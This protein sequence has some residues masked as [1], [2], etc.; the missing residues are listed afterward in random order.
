MQDD[1][2]GHALDHLLFPSQTIGVTVSNAAQTPHVLPDPLI[3]LPGLATQ[4]TGKETVPIGQ[5]HRPSTSTAGPGLN[6]FSSE[7][8]SSLRPNLA[9]D[10]PSLLDGGSS[11]ASQSLRSH[12]LEKLCADLQKEKKA[13]EEEFGRQRKKF[14]NRM[15]QADTELT[16]VKKNMEQASSEVAE[17]SKQLRQKNDEVSS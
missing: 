16:L 3:S 14:M 6:A 9:S 10:T 7:P 1:R 2:S 8:H 15:M 4:H 17:L 11:A 13:M 12:Y 5:V